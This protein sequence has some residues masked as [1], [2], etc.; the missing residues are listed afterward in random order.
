MA[1]V[2]FC[3][4]FIFH[5]LYSLRTPWCNILMHQSM[6]SWPYRRPKN[7]DYIS[8]LVVHSWFNCIQYLYWMSKKLVSVKTALKHDTYKWRKNKT[9]RFTNKLPYFLMACRKVQKPKEK[10]CPDHKFLLQGPLT[11]PQKR[12]TS[13]R[14]VLI[15]YGIIILLK[16]SLNQMYSFTF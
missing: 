10:E 14:H 6:A 5:F 9:K 4:S 8:S 13:L 11:V 1:I 12:K 3:W 16:L 2:L 7:G 15:E